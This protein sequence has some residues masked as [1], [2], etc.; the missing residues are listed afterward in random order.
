MEGLGGVGEL[1]FALLFVGAWFVTM[2]FVLPR[3]GVST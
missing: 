2:R 1:L 3:L